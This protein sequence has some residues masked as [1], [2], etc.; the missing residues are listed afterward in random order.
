VSYTERA[1]VFDC[2]GDKL[3]GVVALPKIQS[4]SIGVLVIVGGPQYRV[5]SHREFVLLS[6]HLAAQGIACMRFDYRGM[7][8][9][10]GEPR[11][12]EDI[13]DD[14]RAA[15]DTFHR[16]VPRLEQVVLWGLCDGASAACFYAHKDQRVAGL[17]LL[18]PWVRT[19]QGEAKTYLKHYYLRRLVD[20]EFWRKL[21]AGRIAIRGSAGEI[22]R[23]MQS[24]AMRGP[25]EDLPTRMA[26]DLELARVPT[27][28]ILSGR[29][30]VAKEFADVVASDPRWN[31]LH[32]AA[33]V[34]TLE[35]AD[36]TFSRSEWR[37]AVAD[38]T[39]SWVT[40]LSAERA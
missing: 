24:A 34:S 31:K 21:L 17:V 23:S 22:A 35:A 12:F 37:D 18:N 15:I 30:Y 27:L 32:A 39:G 6:R 4:A 25:D 10:L 1:I 36:H 9:S 14:I 33:S 38:V 29:D 16:E 26:R 19:Q 3:V 5:G 28:L 11:S 20:P 40:A 8:D 13:D 2:A 7:G